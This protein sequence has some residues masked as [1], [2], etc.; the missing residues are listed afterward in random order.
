MAD[1]FFRGYITQQTSKL[2]NFNKVL[3][4]FVMRIK[5]PFL[6]KK[7]PFF[8]LGAA[9]LTLPFLAGPLYAAALTPPGAQ[10][11]FLASPLG[12]SLIVVVFFSAIALLLRFLYGPKGI[13]REKHWDA[14]NAEFRAAE[15]QKSGRRKAFLRLEALRKELEP[16]TRKE[17]AALQEYIKGFYTGDAERDELI[18]LK[19]EHSLG[20]FKNAWAIIQGEELLW[21]PGVARVLLLAALYHDLGRFE[22]IR[23]QQDF[24]DNKGIDHAAL[25]ARLLALPRFLADESPDTRRL[26][27]AAV[28]L[29]SRAELPARLQAQTGALALA[30][31][32]LRDADKL[33]IIKIMQEGL[34]PGTASDPAI[35]YGLPDDL[36][37]CSEHVLKAVLERRPVYSQDMRCR[38]DFRLR[39]C[40]WAGLLEFAA[41]RRILA[42]RGHLETIMDWLP[43]TEEADKVRSFVRDRL[44]EA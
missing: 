9:L 30:A 34:R 19:D 35:S 26:V 31:R 38:N 5:T 20:V 13:W 14:M 29:H 17:G 42:E 3:I 12:K 25:G 41:T 40:G 10:Q 2:I 24:R 4:L 23:A 27:R 33:D 28:A 1:F 32:A 36:E 44:A 15:A 16:L 6:H 39:L 21:E 43:Q 11:G 7:H 18:R 8:I 37:A 22:Q